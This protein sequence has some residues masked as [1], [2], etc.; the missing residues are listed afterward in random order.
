MKSNFIYKLAIQKLA[1]SLLTY[2]DSEGEVLCTT[3][4]IKFNLVTPKTLRLGVTQ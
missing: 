3:G 4:V 1:S 2:S